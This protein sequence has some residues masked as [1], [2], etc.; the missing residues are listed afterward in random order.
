MIGTGFPAASSHQF[1]KYPCGGAMVRLRKVLLIM[2]ALLAGV[3]QGAGAVQAASV[4]SAPTEYETEA[5]RWNRFAD[6]LYALHKKRVAG[7]SIEIKERIGHYFQQP[8]FYKEQSFYNKKNGELL[9][10]IQ[11]ET[12]N[13]ENI[14]VIQIFFYDDKGRP[15]HDYAASFRTG[16]HDD[17]ATTEISVFD[18]P[19]G[20]QVFRQFNASNE[21]I[22]EHCEGKWKGKPVDIKLDVV[23]LEE[24]RD[25]PD[26]VM[27]SPQYRACFGRLPKTAS[28]YL[29]PR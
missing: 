9:S 3:V 24:F 14:H 25:E 21:I 18:Y 12:K 5:K 13:P 26:T 2:S 15:S 4:L 22:Y 29:P 8:N 1:N 16:D 7:K 19:R 23:D 11:W 17:P 6:D 20:L 10:I 28:R 27:T